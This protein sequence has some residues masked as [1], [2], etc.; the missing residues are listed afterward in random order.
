[1]SKKD[2][3]QTQ[4][5]NSAKKGKSPPKPP[6]KA[7]ADTDAKGTAKG[8]TSGTAK[9]P[10]PPHV[11][12]AKHTPPPQPADRSGLGGFLWVVA[13]LAVVVGGGY[14]TWPLWSAHVSAWLPALEGE[15]DPQVAG[16]LD[17][18]SEMEKELARIRE[19][20]DAIADL[21][22]VRGALNKD[23]EALMER[24]GALEGQLQAM[25][26]MVAATTPPAAAIDAN[27][28]LENLTERLAR[29]EQSNQSIDAVLGRVA[30]LEAAVAEGA[31]AA[32][33]AGLE[34]TSSMR[35]AQTQELVLAA[36]HLRE[37]LAGPR[38]F[39]KALDNFKALGGEAR[40]ITDIVAD[41]EAFAD[42]GIPTGETLGKELRA[43]TRDIAAA[44]PTSGGNLLA[45]TVRR[46]KALVR[47]ER[48]DGSA[49]SD[50]GDSES[51]GGV[52]A[53]LGDAVGAIRQGDLE[54]AI[55]RI[56]RLQ[57]PAAEAAGPWLER[58]RA[59][60]AAQLAMSALHVYAV[61]LL[62]PKSE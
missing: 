27:R 56:E 22:S 40:D 39:R 49:P 3:A 11:E 32:A 54:A 13:L 34:A 6:A 36:G 23:M 43:A 16:T 1:L 35:Q 29:L 44:V 5:G 38:P 48:T 20:G 17:R 46:L 14:A 31:Q 45:Q 58:A 18:L 57:G 51:A 53:V 10:P 50:G 60:R 61:S 12:H 19:S 47:I 4:Q 41:I 62:A 15:V 7:A 42:S 33:G 21:E 2:K 9:S 37:S 25:R 24:I 55:V 28:S 52:E 26:K 30:G 8:E 59:R